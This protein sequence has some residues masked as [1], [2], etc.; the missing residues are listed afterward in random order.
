MSEESNNEE[1]EEEV[2]VLWFYAIEAG[3]YYVSLSFCVFIVRD[4][5]IEEKEKRYVVTM[6]TDCKI[7]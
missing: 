2:S 7:L 4:Q 1:P 5:T 3:Y 6:V